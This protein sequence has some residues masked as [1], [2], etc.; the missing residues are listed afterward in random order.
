MANTLTKHETENNKG[1]G[2]GMS[3]CDNNRVPSTPAYIPYY[4]L[5][6]YGVEK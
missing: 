6:T 4:Q 5:K 3:L 2:R 1:Q